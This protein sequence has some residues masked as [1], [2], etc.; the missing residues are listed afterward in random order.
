MARMPSARLDE[1]ARRVAQHLDTLARLSRHRPFHVT[2]TDDIDSGYPFYREE[3]GRLVYRVKECGQILREEWV[4]DVDELVRRIMVD[5]VFEVAQKPETQP[6]LRLRRRDPRRQ[7]FAR[8]EDWLAAM[9]PAWGDLERARH[10]EILKHWPF[11][12][13]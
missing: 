2:N 3:H 8:T 11:N 13:S 10:A 6:R 9:D 4:D 5:L 7:M 12:D 1:V